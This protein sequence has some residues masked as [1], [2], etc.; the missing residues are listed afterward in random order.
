MKIPPT[1]GLD[2]SKSAHQS[3]ETLL[4]GGTT[5]TSGGRDRK[6]GQS[7]TILFGRSDLG[8]NENV[9]VI[10]GTLAVWPKFGFYLKSFGLPEKIHYVCNKN[11]D[12]DFCSQS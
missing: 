4:S 6:N 3:S 5:L 2:E 1:P 8:V 12:F 11:Q 9:T 10:V 7:L